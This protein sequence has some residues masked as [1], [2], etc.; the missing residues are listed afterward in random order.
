M[1]IEVAGNLLLSIA[2]E[3]WIWLSAALLLGM[4]LGWLSYS[5]ESANRAVEQ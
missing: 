3:N 2:K 1:D 4:I 5:P